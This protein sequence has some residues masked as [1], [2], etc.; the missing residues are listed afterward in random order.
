M[1]YFNVRFIRI[2][3]F[4]QLILFSKIINAN[5]HNDSTYQTLIEN[6]L[7]TP[8]KIEKINGNFL[9][10]TK[11]VVYFNRENI[12]VISAVDRFLALFNQR[13]KTNLSAVNQESLNEFQIII[14]NRNQISQELLLSK[15]DLKIHGN[16]AYEINIH[17]TGI[18]ISANSPK[19]VNWA[20]MTVAQLSY[21]DND[22]RTKIPAVNIVDWP[23]YTWRGY[24]LDTG[25]APYSVEQIKRT[26]R[27][28]SAFKLNFL[29]LREGDDEL[30]AIKYDH[31]PLG[32]HNPYAL[33][34]RDLAE[35]IDYGENYGVVL[36]LEVESLGHAAAKRLHYPDLIEGDMYGDYWPGFSHMRKA[37][38]KVGNPETYQ[39]L[40]SIYKE[41]FPLLKKPMVHLGLDEVRLSRKEQAQHLSR[42][43]PI[44]DRVG[45]KSG[46]EMEMIV[47]SDAPPTP[48]EYQDRVIRCLWVYDDSVALD[49]QYARI[50]GIDILTQYGC[51]QKVFMSGGSGTEHQ[52]YSKG[53]YKGA[54]RNLATWAML[55]QNY[56]NFIG[57]LAVQW[58][59]NIIDEWFPNFLMAADFGWKVPA[60]V[61]N[62]Q[63]SMNRI[64]TNL[65]QFKDFTDPAPSAV[66]RPA[67]DGI[68]LNGKNWDEDIMTGKKAAP[69]VEISP[70]GEFFHGESSPI[71]IKS[72][73]P[74]TKIYYTINGNEP[75]RQSR[76]YYEPFRVKETTTVRAKGFLAG[77][78]ESYT[79]TQVFASLDFQD[80]NRTESIPEGIRYHYYLT[81]VYSVLDI[82]EKDFTGSGLSEK[83]TI[84]DQI[85]DEE[86]FGLIFSGYIEIKKEG[87]Y[88][89]YLN[90]NDG[91]K[92]FVNEKELIDND[93]RHPAVEKIGK[94]SLRIGY[95]PVKVTYFQNGGGQALDLKWSTQWFEKQEVPPEVLFH[96][97]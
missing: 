7:P 11:S 96:V 90:S 28:C 46:H 10:T 72:N 75:N 69:V 49:N 79:K 94:I 95:Y 6:L 65:Q 14:Q 97:E 34:I 58:G 78:P 37:N 84:V 88:T 15:A 36:F 70:K 85:Q 38:L 63:S 3:I 29:M 30:N 2:I 45:R 20:L 86:K 33:T 61:P 82:S 27:I 62:Y 35:I 4:L 50:Q 83:I 25:R 55:G 91:S 1:N 71:V 54:F 42:L 13:N 87:L 19:G 22:N 93:G 74:Q 23:H 17:T 64:T 47:W 39:L 81:D 40:E 26:I 60:K 48:V 12:Q 77:R 52:P 24:M 18:G 73:L 66:D 32:H 56:H 8:Q 16:E 44:V 76:Y 59:T 41:L 68:W 53:T 43:L 67:W 9:L 5:P 80:P 51:R 21:K 57:L 92:L 89:F 31:I